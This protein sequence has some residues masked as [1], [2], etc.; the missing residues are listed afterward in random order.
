MSALAHNSI[1]FVQNKGQWDGPFL[2]K[3]K[4]P[5]STIFLEQHTITYLMEDI[6]NAVKLEAAKHGVADVN[7]NYN[8]YAYKMNFVNALSSVSVKQSKIQNH[9]YNYFLG[10]DS[11]RWKTELHPSLALDYIGMYDGID[12]HIASEKGNIKYD[13]IVAPHANAAQ[14]VLEYVG[15]QHMQIQKGN[16][17]LKTSL[18]NVTELKPYA[19]QFIEGAKKIVP[20]VYHLESN[21]ITYEFP[22]GYDENV[23]LIIDPTVVFATFTGSTADN[24]GFTATYDNQGNFYAGGFVSDQGYPTTTGAFQINYA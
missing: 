10:A 11:S 17:V 6:A 21:K 23:T 24:W 19:Y 7:S 15:L 14:I 3:A 8:F 9:Y 20:C 2:F 13:C 12:I 5:L 22:N 18:G 1:E 4:T 16:L